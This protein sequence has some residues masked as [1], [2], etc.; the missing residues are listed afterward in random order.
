LYVL[1]KKD[2]ASRKQITNTEKHFQT[3]RHKNTSTQNEYNMKEIQLVLIGLIAMTLSMIFF[4][5]TD[6]VPLQIE[7]REMNIIISLGIG[8][9]ILVVVKRQ[10]RNLHEIIHTQHKMINKMHKMIKEEM[11]FMREMQK[12][13]DL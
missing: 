3:L 7:N 13:K 1:I 4:Y 9:L 2:T 8:L 10:D 12:K 5:L 11:S 6:M